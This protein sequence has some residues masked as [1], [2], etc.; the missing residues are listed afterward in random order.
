MYKIGIMHGPNLNRLG[1]RDSKQYGSF[2]LKDLEK[3]I[4]DKATKLGCAVEFFQSNHE[5]ELIETLHCWGDS[6]MH[7]LIINAGGYSHSSVALRDAIEVSRLPAIE[8]HISNIYGREDF[9][10]TSITASACKGTIAGLGK[11]GYFLAL[12]ALLNE[13]LPGVEAEV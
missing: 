11:Y 12:N 5:G 3:E 13:I 1:E 10:R 7:G 4:R 6:E 8:V 2:T 9:R